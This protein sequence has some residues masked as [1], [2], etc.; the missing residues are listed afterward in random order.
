MAGFGEAT[1]DTVGVSP[2]KFDPATSCVYAQ[3]LRRTIM[4]EDG[5]TLVLIETGNVCF[6]GKSVFTPTPE[7]SIGV[8]YNIEATFTI[9]AGTG[10]FAGAHGAGTD[11]SKVDAK[12]DHASLLRSITLP[13]LGACRGG[14]KEIPASRNAPG[15]A[16]ITLVWLRGFRLAARRLVPDGRAGRVPS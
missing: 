3:V 6:P 12:S 11:L 8:P 4:L 14:T 2:G 15:L 1:S 5:S 16:G 13:E 9:V 10:V 7:A